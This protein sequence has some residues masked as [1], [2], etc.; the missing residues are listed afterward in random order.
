MIPYVIEF[1]GGGGLPAYGILLLSALTAAF[2]LVHVRARRAGID[3]DRLVPVYMMAGIGGLIGAKVLYAVAVEPARLLADPGSLFAGGGFAFY[4]GAWGGAFAVLVYARIV[5]LPVWRLADLAAPAVVL[6][7]GVG[8]IGCWMAGCCHGAPVPGASTTTGLLPASFDGGQ[9]WV[10]PA[11]PYLTNEF[12]GGVG[13][14]MDVP[15]YPTQMWSVGVGLSLAALLSWL[16]TRRRFDGQIAA[17]ALLIEPPFRIAIES[18]RADE[19]GYIVSWAV[20]NAPVALPGLGSAGELA[21]VPVVGVTTSQ[22]IA[23]L[24]MAAGVWLYKVRSKHPLEQA[25]E[26]ASRFSDIPDDLL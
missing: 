11:F 2:G 7:L 22:G 21:A 5:A 4:G 20:D 19:R 3:P 16:W 8:R 1:D 9:L 24:M 6:G 14:L 13:R 17:I 10:Q 12:H 15:L 25:S 18:F 26:T 23:V